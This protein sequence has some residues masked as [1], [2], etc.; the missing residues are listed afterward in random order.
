MKL[1][2]Y[3]LTMIIFLLCALITGCMMGALVIYIWQTSL[4]SEVQVVTV[5]VERIVEVVETIEVEKVIEVPVTPIPV[6]ENEPYPAPTEVIPTPIPPT[7][8]ENPV[9]IA[10]V[11]VISIRPAIEYVT[12]PDIVR[13]NDP[14]IVKLLVTNL[15]NVPWEETYSVFGYGDNILPCKA[16]LSRVLHPFETMEIE[17]NCVAGSVTTYGREAP[18]TWNILDNNNNFIPLGVLPVGGGEIPKE[19]VAPVVPMQ[20]LG[21]EYRPMPDEYD[22]YLFLPGMKEWQ[23]KRGLWC[24]PS[25]GT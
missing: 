15:G 7:P 8:T 5:E 3:Q 4:P 24:D 23:Q 6:I 12:A 1:N 25:T 17:A 9:Y 22:K 20:V 14:F 10:E 19:A 2:N 16:F 11:E 18:I 13:V 21:Y